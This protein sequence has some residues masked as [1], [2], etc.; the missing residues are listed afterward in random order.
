MGYYSQNIAVNV[1]SQPPYT[2]RGVTSEKST[3]FNQNVGLDSLLKNSFFDWY[4]ATIRGVS[5]DEFLNYSRQFLIGDIRPS[6]PVNPSYQSAFEMCLGERV[7]YRCSFGGSHD[8]IYVL[9]TSDNSPQVSEFLRHEYPGHSVS[10]LDVANDYDEEAVFDSLCQMGFYLA[11]KYGLK[12][13][14]IG[15]WHTGKSGRT[16]CIGSRKS[17]AYLRIY[18]KGKEQRSKGID[19]DASLDW[20]RMELEVKPANKYSKVKAS[21]MQPLEFFSISQWTREIADLLGERGLQAM[22]LGTVRNIASDLDRKTNFMLY[23]YSAV[24]QNIVEQRLN[25]N[26]RDLGEYLKESMPK[27][28]KAV[29]ASRSA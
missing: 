27:A 11:E 24:I 6:K 1:D 2:N 8:S 15:D 20:V 9:S 17:V 23:Q 7:I 19:P 3:K 16:L 29:E 26:W 14:Q 25:G 28:K 10:R 18:E 12:I 22:P 4:G 13:N 21:T 5:A